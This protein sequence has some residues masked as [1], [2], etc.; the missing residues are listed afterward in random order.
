MILYTLAPLME[1]IFPSLEQPDVP[2]VLTCS[3][4]GGFIQ[5]VK[6][7]KGIR[8]DRVIST[9]PKTYLSKEF[10]LGAEIPVPPSH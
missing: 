6:T 3:V 4:S 5:G 8:I 2:G 7:S 1:S 10:D 9:D